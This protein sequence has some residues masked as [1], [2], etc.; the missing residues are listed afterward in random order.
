MI[1]VRKIEFKN[2]EVVVYVG[3]NVFYWSYEHFI[4]MSKSGE[5]I[6]V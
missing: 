3:N 4:E 5:A 2:D 6:R 1:K